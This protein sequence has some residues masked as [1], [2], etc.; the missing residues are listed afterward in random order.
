[1]ARVGTR[2]SS[3][4]SVPSVSSCKNSSVSGRQPR[5]KAWCAAQS[6]LHSKDFS[7][8]CLGPPSPS[9]ASGESPPFRNWR[10]RI[11]TGLL[12]EPVSP[13]L[14]CSSLPLLPSVVVSYSYF[15][16]ACAEFVK[17]FVKLN[18]TTLSTITSAAKLKHIF[19]PQLALHQQL[20]LGILPNLRH[21]WRTKLMRLTSAVRFLESVI[22]A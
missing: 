21:S 11:N 8:P 20:Q 16:L 15:L 1:M 5:A 3:R 18:V 6:L 9:S 19:P 22:A 14:L 7:S 4:S 10:K 13:A 17:I 12:Q 2:V